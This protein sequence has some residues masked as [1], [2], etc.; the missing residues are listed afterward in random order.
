MMNV[1]YRAVEIGNVIP[2]TTATTYVAGRCVQLVS[3]STQSATS[4]VLASVRVFGLVK[5]NYI[6]GVIDEC[7]LGGKGI[8]GAGRISVLC[9]GIA[10]VQQVVYSGVSYSV[11][12]QAQT[13]NCNDDIYATPA[14]GVLTNQSQTG[15]GPNGITSLRVGRVITP[16]TSPGNGTPMQI[17]VECA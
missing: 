13:Y 17:T 12:D 10:T 2:V 8:Y 1:D 5:E 7:N 14:T 15:M 9:Q 3:G 16:P 11:Y 6:S 4:V